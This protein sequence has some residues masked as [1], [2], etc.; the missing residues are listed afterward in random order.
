MSATDMIFFQSNPRFA[1]KEKYLEFYD[2]FEKTGRIAYGLAVYQF[3]K[4]DGKPFINPE[5]IN[6]TY[7][8]N[9]IRKTTTC[10]EIE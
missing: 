2:F 1:T 8:L 6:A 10:Q 5:Y 9:G 3:I 7:E 4:K